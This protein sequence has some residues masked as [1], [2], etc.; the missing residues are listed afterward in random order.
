MQ[1]SLLN[2][3]PVNIMTVSMRLYIHQHVCFTTDC[4][5]GHARQQ[6]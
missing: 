5:D 2:R 3:C 4:S 1:K 6:T